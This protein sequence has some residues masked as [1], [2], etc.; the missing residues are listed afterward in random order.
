MSSYYGLGRLEMGNYDGQRHNFVER[1]RG[2][3]E[4][5][6]DN[7]LTEVDWNLKF[8]NIYNEL[9]LHQENSEIRR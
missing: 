6:D 3:I 5:I 7:D 8:K 1:L 2:N 4:Y 9:L